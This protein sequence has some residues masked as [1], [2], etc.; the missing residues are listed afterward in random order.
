MISYI[1]E[2]CIIFRNMKIKFLAKTIV[3]STIN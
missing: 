2:V 1:N 3:F